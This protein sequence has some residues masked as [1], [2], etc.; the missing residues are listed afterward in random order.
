MIEHLEQQ[1]Q[2]Y[3]G[4]NVNGGINGRNGR[5][6]RWKEEARDRVIRKGSY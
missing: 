2:Q 5:S 6:G 4:S 1:Q 3:F